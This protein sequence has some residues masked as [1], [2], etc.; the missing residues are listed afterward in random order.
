MHI[1][2]NSCVRLW[3]VLIYQDTLFGR[4]EPKTNETNDQNLRTK[5]ILK[6]LRCLC[7]YTAVDDVVAVWWLQLHFVKRSTRKVGKKKR[8]QRRNRNNKSCLKPA[9]FS[10]G[11]TPLDGMIKI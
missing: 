3:L 2:G 5:D 10:Q 1:N 9:T 11:Y 8:D 4:A 6:E 7:V